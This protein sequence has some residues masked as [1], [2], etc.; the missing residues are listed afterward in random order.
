[1]KPVL[2]CLK[3]IFVEQLNVIDELLIFFWLLNLVIVM[4]ITKCCFGLF[5]SM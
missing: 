2:S 1:M 3:G 4:S 5:T